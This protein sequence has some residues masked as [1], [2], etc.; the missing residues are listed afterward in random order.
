MAALR[1]SPQ[2]MKTGASGA[3]LGDVGGRYRPGAS[4]RRVARQR[5]W[6]GRVMG[7]EIEAPAARREARKGRSVFLVA[8]LARRQE[9]QMSDTGDRR[10]CG[11]DI[12]KDR[13]WFACYHQTEPR[14]RWYAKRMA[15]FAMIWGACGAG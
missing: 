10:C 5:S 7:T 15:H 13:L 3:M 9:D 12:H 1:S 11:L 14:A 4:W 8:S 6:S 2:K